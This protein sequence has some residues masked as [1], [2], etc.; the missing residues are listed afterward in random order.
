MKI[1]LYKGVN[2]CLLISM[3]ICKQ[4]QKNREEKISFFGIKNKYQ[5]LGKRKIV[6]Y[7]ISKYAGW[8]TYKVNII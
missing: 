4:T 3:Q 1:S 7:K 6:D 2:V 8:F 5:I